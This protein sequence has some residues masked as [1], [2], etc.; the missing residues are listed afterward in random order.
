MSDTASVV[1][2][3]GKDKMEFVNFTK[4]TRNIIVNYNFLCISQSYNKDKKKEEAQTL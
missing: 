3:A 4:N 2:F 1:C